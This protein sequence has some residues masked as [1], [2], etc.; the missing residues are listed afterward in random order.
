MKNIAIIGGG[1]AGFFAAI[2]I[3]ELCNNHRI[4]I[5]E[6][7]PTVLGKVRVSGGGRC[8]VTHHCFDPSLLVKFYPRGEKALLG[9]FNRFGPT[10]TVSWFE[11][12]GVE[13]KTEQDGRMFPITDD[14][15]TIIQCLLDAAKFSGVTINTKSGIESFEPLENGF[16]GWKLKFREGP[17]LFADVVIL[18]TGSSESIW[19]QLEALGISIQP[20]APSLFTFNVRDNRIKDL[21]GLSVRNA[22]VKVIGNKLEAEGPLLITHW[23]MSGPGILKLSSWGAIQLKLLNYKFRI[24]INFLPNESQEKVFELLFKNKE[25]YPKKLLVNT[26]VFEEIPKRL[27]YKL[28]E[29]AQINESKNWSD[30]NKVQL[31][32]LTMELTEGIYE[33]NGKST[34]K[35]EFVTCGGV[36]LNEIDFKTMQ[37]K[38]YQNIFVCG[39]II[40]VDALTGGFN[41]QNA[42]TTGWIAG[43][44]IAENFEIEN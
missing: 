39:E 42:W 38:K 11:T 35:E 32:K 17:E 30:V 25:L 15:N 44:S 19:K 26:T 7:S 8:N 10:D 3:A 29:A 2:R 18:A 40:N 28:L 1:A 21:M 41:F 27:W 13:L 31:R 22:K 9:P 6:K 14:S 4:T 36:D 16:K 33:V 23:G 43:T 24:S 34:N 5:Y 37:L 20:P 12:R